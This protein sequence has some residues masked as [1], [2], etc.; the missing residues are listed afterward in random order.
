MNL[1]LIL[2]SAE[3]YGALWGSLTPLSLSLPPCLTMAVRIIR[4]D[5]GSETVAWYT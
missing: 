1:A 3:T 2:G 4:R 5:Q